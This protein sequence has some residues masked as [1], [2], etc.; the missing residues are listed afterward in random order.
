M[1]AFSKEFHSIV[2]EQVPV[3]HNQVSHSQV[4]CDTSFLALVFLPMRRA[5]TTRPLSSHSN[6]LSDVP[7]EKDLPSLHGSYFLIDI[8]LELLDGL[9]EMIETLLSDVYLIQL[10]HGQ[11]SLLPKARDRGKVSG[12]RR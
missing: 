9:L 3:G 6:R 10:S 7:S 12:A 8:L 2:H 1:I 5:P 4:Y 11:P